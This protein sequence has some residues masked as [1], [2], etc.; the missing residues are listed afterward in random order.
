MKAQRLVLILAGI[1]LV[2][3]GI[4]SYLLSSGNLVSKVPFETEIKNTETMSDSDEVEAIETDL[5][6]T[7]LSDIDKELNDIEAELSE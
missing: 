2:I 6:E 4:F 7:D 3:L 1:L 5:S